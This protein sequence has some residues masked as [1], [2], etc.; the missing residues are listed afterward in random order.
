MTES[1]LEGFRHITRLVEDYKDGTNRF[2]LQDEALFLCLLGNRVIGICGLNRDPYY[3][4][5]VGRVRRLYV[6]REFRRHKIGRKLTEA[7]IHKAKNYNRRLILKTDNPDASEFYKTLGFI[8]VI[9]DD[10]MTHYIELT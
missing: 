1:D 6:L 3:G 8:E 4:E 9:G 5:G 2:D 7:V 10:K